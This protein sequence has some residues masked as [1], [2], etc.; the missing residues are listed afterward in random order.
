MLPAPP[1]NEALFAS[2]YVDVAAP[3]EDTAGAIAVLVGGSAIGRDGACT[4]ARVAVDD[5]Y[6]QFEIRQRDP[7]DL[8]GWPTVLKVMPDEAA[9][10]ELV[11]A[12]VRDLMRGLIARG[13]RVLAQCDY[14][15]QLPGAGEVVSAL[16]DETSSS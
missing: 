14:A 11:I 1:M 7:D 16:V 5:D 9:P 6:G 10:A 3:A 2:I 12:Q 8:P 13:W 4:W 15:D